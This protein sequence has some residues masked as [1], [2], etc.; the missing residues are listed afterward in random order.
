MIQQTGPAAPAPARRRALWRRS[1]ATLP[2]GEHVAVFEAGQTSAD[3]TQLLLVHGM[4]HWTQAAWDFVAAELEATHRIVAF[5]L[6]GFGESAKP[7]IAYAL[8]YFT[9]AVRAVAVAAGLRCFTLVGHSLGGMIA[10]NYAAAY[11]QEIRLLALLDPAGFLRTPKFVLRIAASG[12]LT[13]L[14]RRMR[15]SQKF[16]RRTFEQAV[17]DKTTIPE[18]YHARAF[19]LSRDATLTRAFVGV[20]AHALQELLH[21]GDLHRRFARYTGPALIVWGARDRFVPIRALPAAR[22]V[23]PRADVL[24]LANC[25]HCPNLE[26]PERVVERLLANGA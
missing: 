20:Y 6:P 14:L 11:P 4:G 8:P 21:I 17:F 3:A 16:V 7:D 25:G 9:A 1:R 10:A 2:G 22:R 12:P 15:P 13:W 18:D 24:E 23:Y 19:A 26:F 5:D